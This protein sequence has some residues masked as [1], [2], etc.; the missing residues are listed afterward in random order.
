MALVDF[1][2][3]SNKLQTPTPFWKAAQLISFLIGVSIV[4]CLFVYP[5]Y[6][7][8]VFWNGLIPL[9]PFILVISAGFWRNI[10]PLGSTSLFFRNA[11]LSKRKKLSQKA[12]GKL[13][14]TGI[15]LLFLI[16][17]LRHVLFDINAIATAWLLIGVAVVA[18]ILGLRYEWKSAWCSSLCPI[19]PIERLYGLKNVFTMSNAQCASCSKC[20]IP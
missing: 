8:H 16:A 15:V 5:E 12:I 3:P 10:C 4:F 18:C 6:G 7:L 11:D 14:L 13:S 20:V 9:A 17:P 1:G 19:H 2:P